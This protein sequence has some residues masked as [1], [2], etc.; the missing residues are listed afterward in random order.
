MLAT[1]EQKISVDDTVERSGPEITKKQTTGNA[2]GPNDLDDS[3]KEIW[4]ESHS[5][6]Q[7]RK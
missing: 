6:T 2:T 1:I 3:R 5:T 7:N 4:D